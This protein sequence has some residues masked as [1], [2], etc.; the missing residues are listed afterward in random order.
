MYVLADTH[1]VRHEVA[2]NLNQLPEPGDVDRI[3]GLIESVAMC[4]ESVLC[5]VQ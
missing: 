2:H 3:S 1:Y 5:T 4:T